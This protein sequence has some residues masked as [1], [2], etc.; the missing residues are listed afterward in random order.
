[1]QS[2]NS[3]K[4]KVT[5]CDDIDT[6][7]LLVQER[8]SIERKK[9]LKRL[10]SIVGG[11]LFL[12]WMS[13][14]FAGSNTPSETTSQ[15]A[16]TNLGP[17]PAADQSAGTSGDPEFSGE[18][19]ALHAHR[20]PIAVLV[21]L[22]QELA[23]IEVQKSLHRQ[24]ENQLDEANSARSEQKARAGALKH[25]LD[26]LSVQI[27]QARSRLDKRDGS[28]VLDLNIRVEAYDELL[29]QTR[30]VWGKAN[31]LDEPFNDLVTKFNAQY[32]LV[33]QMVDAYNAKIRQISH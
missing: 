6:L 9:M 25:Q 21:E 24:L 12:L 29:K 15:S 19:E 16:Q 8:G 31:A 11:I 1:M 4:L 28:A 5:S 13:G 33:N 30:E 26:L 14:V 17:A 23:A 18:G 22:Q 10:A 2:V 20:V 32:Q 7:N 27:D 3:E